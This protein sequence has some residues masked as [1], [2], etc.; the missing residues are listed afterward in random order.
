MTTC[1]FLGQLEMMI[2]LYVGLGDGLGVALTGAA[3]TGLKVD[4]AV[5]GLRVV[6][7]VGRGKVSLD[8][9][10]D[11]GLAVKGFFEGEFVLAM[12]TLNTAINRS[13]TAD[14]LIML[15][16]V[17][18]CI[19]CDIYVSSSINYDTIYRAKHEPTVCCHTRSSILTVCKILYSNSCTR[20]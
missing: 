14:D 8:E 4:L 9:G 11:V 3:T 1:E 5:A 13:N 10:L 2:G 17:S 6:L 12:T 19:Y 18:I 16:E 15:I 7:A 20:Y